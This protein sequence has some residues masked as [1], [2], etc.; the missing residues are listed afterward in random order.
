[1]FEKKRIY[2]WDN[3]KSCL[4]FLV[5]LGHFLIPIT[6]YGKS[7]E[8]C[9]YFI[10]LF[11]MPA[12]VFVSGYFSKNYIQKNNVPDETKI[13]G[14]LILFILYKV[15]IWAISS[16]F[17]KELVEFTLLVESG[18]PW[19][20]LAMTVWYILLPLFA[21]FKWYAS[22]IVTVIFAL[23]AGTVGQIGPFLCLSR[24][25]VYFPFFLFGYYFKEEYIQKITSIKG[26]VIGAGII[27]AMVGFVICFL[28]D[29]KSFSGLIYGNRPYDI[30]PDDITVTTAIIVRGI[31]YLVG[32][33]M[34]LSLM[35]WIPK[36]K[37]MISYIGSRTLSI[38]ILH[39]LVKT[40]LEQLNFY[41]MIHFG[42]IKLLIIICIFCLG[43]TII[44]S[45]KIFHK[46]FNSVFKINYK[47]ILK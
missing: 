45:A 47:K 17:S 14:F 9:Y 34:T 1:M 28:D 2:Y 30:L 12:F 38:Y 29:I 4:I 16:F 26:K 25:V 19:Y 15:L 46:C 36:K 39:R 43:L 6:E 21:K 27:T 11:H 32:A 7:I 24:I 13:L 5:V 18:A 22:L 23:Y 41:D 3:L 31:L 37:L 33:C 8:S 20:M 44:L 42:G 40:V 10:Y 35:A